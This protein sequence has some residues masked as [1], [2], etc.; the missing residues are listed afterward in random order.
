MKNNFYKH[1]CLGCS[2]VFGILFIGVVG[3]VIYACLTYPMGWGTTQSLVKYQQCM[4]NEDYEG[5]VYWAKRNMYYHYKHQ[6]KLCR[7]SP[8]QIFVPIDDL[9][10][11]YEGKGD[12]EAALELYR[13]GHSRP[14]RIGMKDNTGAA[15][16]LYQLNRKTE[17][18]EEYCR[19]FRH[20]AQKYLSLNKDEK[21]PVLQQVNNIVTINPNYYTKDH[22]SPFSSYL[23]FLDFMEE[24]Y[25]KLGS[26]PEYE[27]A[28]QLFR[29][30]KNETIEEN[31]PRSKAS[32]ELDTL[33]NKIREERKQQQQQ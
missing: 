3:I 27:E 4:K 11:A 7:E 8:E 12:W 22:C 24:E 19:S 30:I 20:K 2:I 10:R 16:V 5:A 9:A 32:D 6:I 21:N 23:N 13:Y 15:R 28:M 31:L 25:V 26:P 29:A 18:F 14:I 1:S 33:R 17:A